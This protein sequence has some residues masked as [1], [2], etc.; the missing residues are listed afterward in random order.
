[1]IAGV[2]C[3]LGSCA[4][5]F[6]PQRDARVST[7]TV[8]LFDLGDAGA[9]GEDGNAGS[10]SSISQTTDSDLAGFFGDPCFDG[11]SN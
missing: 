4:A 1:M 11:R 8:P 9:T 3:L 7:T 10:S 6:T 5:F 2:A